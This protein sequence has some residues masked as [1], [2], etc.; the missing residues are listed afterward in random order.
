MRHSRGFFERT[1]D[2]NSTEIA[3]IIIV[4]VCHGIDEKK[5][6]MCLSLIVV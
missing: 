1:V 4:V 3:K 2:K 5:I 6:K